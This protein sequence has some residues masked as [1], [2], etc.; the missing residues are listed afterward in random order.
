[1]GS[2]S[3]NQWPT[4]RPPSTTHQTTTMAMSLS[5]TGPEPSRHIRRRRQHRRV[6]QELQPSRTLSPVTSTIPI[7]AIILCI[8]ADEVLEV[9]DLLEDEQDVIAEEAQSEPPEDAADG[10]S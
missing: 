7:I 6:R 9:Q 10:E 1:M 3:E 5:L 4:W 2:R 8:G